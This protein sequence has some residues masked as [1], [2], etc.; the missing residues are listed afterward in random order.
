[1]SQQEEDTYQVLGP[2][3]CT[4]PMSLPAGGQPSRENNAPRGLGPPAGPCHQTEPERTK[5]IAL[6]PFPAWHT[7]PGDAQ[8]WVH[9]QALT[10][11]MLG[12]ARKA[13]IFQEANLLVCLKTK[14]PNLGLRNSTC[15]NLSY[16]CIL[17][18]GRGS[19]QNILFHN[20]KAERMQQES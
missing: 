11:T 6:V 17:H 2:G 19:H 8:R 5:Q 1:M 14:G 18:K 15:G 10:G 12:S 4:S 3:P 9:R 7:E 13:G 16:G 20:L